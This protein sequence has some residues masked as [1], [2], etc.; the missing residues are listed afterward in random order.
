M[1]IFLLV[2]SFSKIQ[3]DPN[4]LML[5]ITYNFIKVACQTTRFQGSIVDKS[6][7]SR[8]NSTCLLVV[9]TRS[10]FSNF[11]ELPSHM[12]AAPHLNIYLQNVLD[13]SCSSWKRR[14]TNL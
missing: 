1:L 2:E 8:G 12:N 14:E 13:I 4:A 11:Y 6:T 10:C 3:I 9:V 7:T 5:P